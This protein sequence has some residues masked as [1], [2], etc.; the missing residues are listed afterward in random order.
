MI[1]N[2]DKQMFIRLQKIGWLNQLKITF[3][4]GKL[5]NLQQSLCA[6]DKAESQ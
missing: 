5:E 1:R 2:K 6:K 4:N 3:L